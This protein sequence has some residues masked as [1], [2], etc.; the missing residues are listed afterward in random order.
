MRHYKRLSVLKVAVAL[1]AFADASCPVVHARASTLPQIAK[2]ST[3]PL[4]HLPGGGTAYP[5]A[6]GS[7][8]AVSGDGNTMVV[9]A[10]EG[11]SITVDDGTISEAW[12]E[13]CS[14]N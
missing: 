7:A 3:D 5:F 12:R 13:Q 6:F 2:L 10:G 14:G 4:I 9:G 8:V 1:A 11:G